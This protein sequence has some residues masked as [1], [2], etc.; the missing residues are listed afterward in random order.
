LRNK[1]TAKVKNAGQKAK[2]K[3]PEKPP[4]SV[5]S[6]FTFAI[7]LVIPV[8]C[9]RVRPLLGLVIYRSAVGFLLMGS[10]F[11]GFHPTPHKGSRPLDPDY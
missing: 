2:E 6:G 4:H 3:E 8:L 10:F 9:F 5:T 1:G 7:R 11:A